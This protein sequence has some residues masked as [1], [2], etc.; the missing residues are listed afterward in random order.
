MA[1]GIQM[2]RIA[3]MLLAALA[4][5]PDARAQAGET[6]ACL[7]VTNADWQ[8]CIATCTRLIDGGRH[9]GPL[10]SSLHSSRAACYRR[11]GQMAQALADIARALALNPNNGD[12]Y[13]NRSAVYG[14]Q[15][16]YDLSIADATQA[17]RLMPRDPLPRFNRCISYHRSGKSQLAVP[18]CRAAARLDAQYEAPRNFLRGMCLEGVREA[19]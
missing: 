17:I 15:K 3:F 12:A 2:K 11:T 16:R 13:L 8:G 4:A 5:T 6:Q 1:S 10:L 9:R 19:C 7:R 14:Q 18:D